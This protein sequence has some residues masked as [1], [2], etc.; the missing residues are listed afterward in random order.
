MSPKKYVHQGALT[1]L[2][3][4]HVSAGWPV[5]AQI[6]GKSLARS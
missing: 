1:K 6:G 3:F 5:I 2:N 4:F